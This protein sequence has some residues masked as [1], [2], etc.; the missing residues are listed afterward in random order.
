MTSTSGSTATA[1]SA[2]AGSTTVGID[3]TFVND[4]EITLR[5]PSSST[6]LVI[7]NTDGGGNNF[8]QTALDDE[9]AGPSIQSVATAHAPFT[10]NF[11][12]NAPLSGFDGQAAN[13]NWQLQAQDFFSQDTGNIRAFSVIITPAVCDAAAPGAVVTGTKTVSGTF[14]AGGTVTYTVTLTNTGGGAQADNPGNEFTDVLPASLPWSAPP[15]PPAP[16]RPPSA[17]TRSP[18]TA[19]SRPAAR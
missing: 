18:G 7:D 13:G 12:P 3:H 19:P 14:T 6:V 11:T 4:L 10:G 1:C 8:C 5:A 15:P 9:S 2:T 16:P 17:P